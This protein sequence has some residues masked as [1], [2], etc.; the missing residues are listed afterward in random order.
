[1][2]SLT[3]SRKKSIAK[4]NFM[5]SICSRNDY[6]LEERLMFRPITYANA[7]QAMSILLH[8]VEKLGKDFFSGL[9]RQ[10]GICKLAWLKKQDLGYSMSFALHHL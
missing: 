4:H 7:I 8:A 1:M 6:S 2:L 3:L 5:P 10:L 9:D